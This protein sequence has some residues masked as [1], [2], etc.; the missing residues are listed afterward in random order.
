M[1]IRD[2]LVGL[3]ILH[4]TEN[5]PT[6]VWATFEQIDNV[7]GSSSPP[8]GYNFHNPNCTSK[9]VNLS[10][11]ST[12]TVNCTVNTSP[13]YH[14]NLAAPVPI[15]ITRQNPIDPSS[16]APINQ[17][18]QKNIKNLYS[19]SVWQYYQLVDV[20]WSATSQPD[21][22]QPIQSPRNINVSAM[23]SGGNIVANTCLLYTSPSPRDRTRSRMPSSA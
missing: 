13:P 9:T 22:T 19:N 5:Q 17:L 14:L 12:A 20:I 15:Q 16:A 3:H 11:G 6:W 8:D 4:K 2:S 18:M 7:P 10:G 21:P 23:Q 1:C